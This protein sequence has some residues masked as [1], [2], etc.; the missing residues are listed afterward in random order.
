MRMFLTL[1]T[2][3]SLT[4]TSHLALSNCRCVCKDGSTP[5]PD[6]THTPDPDPKPIKYAKSYSSVDDPT[7]KDD[8]MTEVSGIASSKAHKGLFYAHNDSGGQPRLFLVEAKSGQTKAVLDIKKAS[9]RD[10]EDMT[11]APC[12]S[13]KGSC[14]Y[15]ADFGDNGHKRNDYVV[16]EIPEPDQVKDQELTAYRHPFSYP[17]DKSFNAEGFGY[18]PGDNSFY[19]ATKGDDSLIK[20]D[21]KSG[22]TEFVCK[23]EVKGVITAFDVHPDGHKYLVRTYGYLYEF[24]ASPSKPLDCPKPHVS[25]SRDELGI[26]EKQGEAMTYSDDDILS[27]SEGKNP[28]IFRLQPRY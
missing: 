20:L 16:Y 7:L 12:V 10:W 26:K 4:F 21:I 9:A 3:L 1:F 8:R 28:N 15:V 24:A 11:V 14:A 23:P 2:L 19:I 6:T 17:K 18:H 25:Q 22:K 5:V 27:V 13:T